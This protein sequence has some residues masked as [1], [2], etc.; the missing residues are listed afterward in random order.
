M[1]KACKRKILLLGGSA[2]Q[3]TAIETAKRMGLYTVLCDYLP[4][5]PG[6]LHADKFYPVSTTDQEAVLKVAMEEK[7]EGILA[8]ASDPAAPTAAYIAEKLGLPGCPYASVEILCNKDR[9]RAFLADHSFHTPYAAGYTGI[10]EALEDIRGG[11]F[12]FPLIVKPVDSSGS[13]GVGR[14]DLGGE[15]P[16]KLAYAMSFSRAKRIIVEEYVEKYGYQIAGDGLSVDG[17]LVFRCFAN[18]HFDPKCVNPFVPVSASFPYN[19]P[20]EVQ[21]KVHAEIQRLL[22]L[23]HMGTTAYNFD[24]RIDKDYNVY[25]MEVA[26]RDGGN[27]IPD[28]IRYATGVDL[29]E[30]SVRAAMGMP[31]DHNG[32][33][34]PK[35]YWSY[36]AVHSYCDGILDSIRIDPDV[37]THNIIENHLIK[38]PGDAIKAFT[39]ANTTLGILLMKF[40][41]MEEMLHRMD[42]PEEWIQ[43]KLRQAV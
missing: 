30:C 43:V 21:D 42:H 20:E 39:G 1:D 10:T 26:P 19:M 6:R 18:D 14:I 38:K 25:L 31:I 35:G 33:G 41:S 29:V 15:A 3:V 28:I 16:D 24:I 17:Q 32:F 5:N 40:D 9:F 12:K 8:Y 27:Y 2:Q 4:D 22:S 37:E 34:K 13:K 36:F 11:R 23:L 7:I